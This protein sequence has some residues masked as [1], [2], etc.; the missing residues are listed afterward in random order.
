M[1]GIKG[2]T[3]ARKL[4]LALL[5]SAALVSAGV[6]VA[7]YII[8]ANAMDKQARQNLSTLAFERSNQLAAYLASVQADLVATAQAD[9]TIQ[10]LRDFAGA[11]LQIKEP[12]PAAALRHV[13]VASN[14][15]PADQRLLLDTPDTKFTYATPHTKV[16]PHFRAQITAA[17]YSDL[18][19]FDPKGMLVYSTTKQDDFATSFVDGPY[20]TTALAEVMTRAQAIETPTDVA[21]ADFS[22]YPVAGAPIAFF[23]KPVFN[24]QGRKI[25]V[26]A[27]GLPAS[28]LAAVIDNRTG[29]GQTGEMVI[30]GADGIVRSDSPFT[31]E[32]D[33][34]TQIFRSTAIDAALA[35]T[36][37]VDTLPNLRGAESLIA[38]V[39]V[40]VPGINWSL[41]AAMQSA[42]VFA[43]IAEIRNGMLLVAAL[44]LGVVAVAGF[45]FSRTITTPISRLTSTMQ[46]LAQGELD[47]AVPGTGRADELGAMAKAVEVF[48]QNALKVTEMTQDE[49]IAA[50]QRR[51]DRTDMMQ[52]LQSAFGKVVDAASAGDFSQR[53][54]AR[55]SDVELNTLA[56][57]VN[58]LVETVDRGTS[59][60]AGVLSALAQTDLT[61]RVTGEYSGA[62]GQLKDD[63]NAVAEKLTDIVTRLRDT[64]RALKTA[65]GEILSGAN[66]LSERTT[67][68]AATVEETSATMEQLATNVLANAQRARQASEMAGSLTRTAEESGA[69][70]T[71]ATEAMQRITTSSG[72]ISNIIGLIDDIA[73]QTNLLAL[74][75]S[76]E[77]ARAGEAGKGFAVVAVEVRRLAQSAA[78]ASAEIKVLIQQSGTEVAGGSQLVAAAASRLDT[79]LTAAR[80]SNELMA[81]IAH[82]SRAQA[83]SIEEI[84]GAVRVMDE[85]T[86]HNAALVEETNAAIEQTEAQAVALD[87]IVEIFQIA[88]PSTSRRAA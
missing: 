17:G 46:A 79:M 5:L 38:A 41:A 2:L 42:E 56:G 85:M 74:N 51:I 12:D 21:V 84:N 19:L 78:E 70:M 60:T 13:Y 58:A 77:A 43:P 14:P 80:A 61:Q 44:L 65:T 3:I 15:H 33:I 36:P 49:R 20:F 47:S 39:P 52:Q 40:S 68:Q 54:P 8:G 50:E 30:V 11:W 81:G 69:V 25:G 28:K 9:A 26:L 57:S 34:L 35:G 55:F 76:V 86:Q 88:R 82:D 64:S 48:K 27:F 53:V 37:T 67:R 7:S 32:S 6:G 45:V 63:T 18:Y 71:Q 83:V 4:P 16:Q 1:F 23:A 59:E 31:A 75:A 66:D 29:L 10:A 24:A 87:G 73:F 72:K 62:F 22:I